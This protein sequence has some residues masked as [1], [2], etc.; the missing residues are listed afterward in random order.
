MHSAPSPRPAAPPPNIDVIPAELKE[1]RQWVLWRYDLNQRSRKWDKVP[2]TPGKV[3]KAKTNSPST[4]GSFADAVASYQARP[5]YFDGIGYVFAKADP[6]VGGDFDHCLDDAGNLSAFA[7]AHLPMTYSEISPS[8]H[9]IKFIARGTVP[10]GRK[11]PRGELYASGRFFTITGNVYQQQTQIEETQGVI[12]ALYA[13]LTAGKSARS[14]GAKR[15]DH[16]EGADHNG[17]WA[18]QHSDA[19]WEEARQRTRTV[20]RDELRGNPNNLPRAVRQGTQTALALSRDYDELKRRWPWLPLYRED[21]SLDESFIPAIVAQGLR[22]RGYSFPRYAA[23]MAHY[24]GDYYKAKWPG[25]PDLLREELARLWARSQPAARPFT[26]QPVPA[27]AKERHNGPGRPY[28]PDATRAAQLGVLRE[29]LAALPT[30]DFGRVPISTAQLARQMGKTDR[31]IRL[32]LTDLAA[33]AEINYFR[34]GK[35]S[36]VILT[37]QFGA[38]GATPAKASDYDEPSVVA[39]INPSALAPIAE[40]NTD[41]PMA[42]LPMEAPEIEASSLLEETREETLAPRSC[43]SSQDRP[44]ELPQSSASGATLSE[45]ARAFVTNTLVDAETGEIKRRTFRQFVAYVERMGNDAR[46]PEPAL[47]R[48]LRAAQAWHAGEYW[49]D[50]RAAVKAMDD[51]A[52]LRAIHA[53]QRDLTRNVGRRLEGHWRKRLEIA[54]DERQRR[55]LALPPPKARKGRKGNKERAEALCSSPSAP[56]SSYVSSPD[57]QLTLLDNQPSEVTAADEE[58]AVKPAEE[59]IRL[60]APWK[61]RQYFAARASGPA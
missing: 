33:N 29:L 36:F 41:A 19:E 18:S 20:V 56:P 58:A 3:E 24:F 2:Y 10:H 51:D 40:T 54:D 17:G 11:T 44:S 30:D 48:A 31:M 35:Q 61:Y 59:P 60:V 22:G 8:G 32:Y 50:Q 57:Q 13:E 38:L 4:W 5:D 7:R 9:G 27:P 15:G 37:P 28:A 42:I 46:W 39:E 12:D 45:V 26:A 43:V 52:L 14:S 6:Y 21:G 55:G 49:R 25:R 47:R 16:N 23:L 53:R 34:N 1:R